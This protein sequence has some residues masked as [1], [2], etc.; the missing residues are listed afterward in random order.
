MTD[1]FPLPQPVG[2]LVAFDEEAQLHGMPSSVCGR[3]FLSRPADKGQ[4]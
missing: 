4:P 1:N 2:L 3:S